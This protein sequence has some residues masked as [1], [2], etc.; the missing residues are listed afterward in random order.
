MIS[1]PDDAV[2]QQDVERGA[3]VRRQRAEIRDSGA[4]RVQRRRVVVAR[5][6]TLE[7]ALVDHLK[8]LVDA[9]QV[10]P[11]RLELAVLVDTGENGA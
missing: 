9:A 4:E 10:L 8:E 11:C 5:I 7:V 3:I 1:E 6:K 2:G